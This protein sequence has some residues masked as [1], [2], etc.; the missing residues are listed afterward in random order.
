M[1]ATFGGPLP[2]SRSPSPRPLCVCH[3]QKLCQF[4]LGVIG[5]FGA[6]AGIIAERRSKGRVQRARMMGTQKQVSI[7]DV[8]LIFAVELLFLLPVHLAY[9]FS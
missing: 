2:Y 5:V 4:A 9:C 3:I 6:L 1:G 7:C 8:D